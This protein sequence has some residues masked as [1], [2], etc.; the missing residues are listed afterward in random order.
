MGGGLFLIKYLHFRY[1]EPK[2]K[3]P[4]QFTIQ[5]RNVPTALGAEAIKTYIVQHFGNL[6]IYRVIRSLDIE[7]YLADKQAKI[8]LLCE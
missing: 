7:Q 4:S 2:Q 8:D 1:P 3:S 6:E 5:L